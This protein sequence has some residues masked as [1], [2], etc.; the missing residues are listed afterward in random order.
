MAAR[1]QP[2]ERARSQP[3][4]QPGDDRRGQQRQD[5]GRQRAA[6]A[7]TTQIFIGDHAQQRAGWIVDD[8]FPF[9]D[10][11]G[12]GGDVGLAQQR[13]H[14]GRA[15]HDQYAGKQDGDGPDQSRDIIAGQR[16]QHPADRRSQQHQPDDRAVGFSQLAEIEAEAAFEQDQRDCDRHHRFQQVAEDG[17]GMDQAQHRAAD[18]AG[19]QHERDGR[20]AGPPGDPLRAD[21]QYADQ[22][23]GKSLLLHRNI[24]DGT[25]CVR[26]PPIFFRPS[27]TIGPVMCGAS[28]AHKEKGPVDDR[29][30]PILPYCCGW[31]GCAGAAGVAGAAGAGGAAA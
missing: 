18:D 27:G 9:Q 2:A 20:P 12:A 21:P 19:G 5:D 13:Q 1:K 29:P 10:G 11:A 7:R 22:R 31:L 4:D 3:A 8:R 17:M 6:F 15:G 26:H 30:F 25:K 23:D 14:H 28:C 16:S 24:I